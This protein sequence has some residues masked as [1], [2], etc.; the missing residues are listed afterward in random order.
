MAVV[1]KRWNLGM[2]GLV[3]VLLLAAC[4]PATEYVRP[5]MTAQ[6]R[7]ADEKACQDIADWQA[8]DESFSSHPKYPPLRDTQFVDE[9]GPD[10]G[11]RNVSYS[12]RGARA[13]ELTEY[14]MQQRGYK[15]VAVKK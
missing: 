5:N 6:Q 9:G 12:R 15:L 8:L 14:C 13:Y 3:A 4:A 7:D 11:G 1:Q 2:A 10:G